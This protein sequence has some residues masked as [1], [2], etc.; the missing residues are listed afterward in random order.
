VS[1]APTC[2]E[3]LTGKL[4]R[5][6][7]K[8]GLPLRRGEDRRRRLPEVIGKDVPY[9]RQPPDFPGKKEALLVMWFKRRGLRVQNR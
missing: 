5:V 3:G 9:K 7:S 8:N 4:G 6:R 2:D 1:F